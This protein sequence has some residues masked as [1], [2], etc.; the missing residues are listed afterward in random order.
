MSARLCLSLL[1]K[2]VVKRFFLPAF[3]NGGHLLGASAL[4]EARWR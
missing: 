2:S 1:K 4:A 3:G